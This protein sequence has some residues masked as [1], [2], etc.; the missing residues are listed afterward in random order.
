[1][2]EHD[3]KIRAT[4]A[5]EEVGG[6]RE[7]EARL[8]PRG[9]VAGLAGRGDGCSRDGR[10]GEERRHLSARFLDER[11]D[12]PPRCWAILEAGET[13]M[14]GS[15]PHDGGD[16]SFRPVCSRARRLPGRVLVKRLHRPRVE[17]RLL[18]LHL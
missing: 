16:K 4:V 3:L 14:M 13:K 9:V 18:R 15:S 12:A 7:M 5:P 2:R 11:E 8:G 10:R 1:M 6:G 17:Q